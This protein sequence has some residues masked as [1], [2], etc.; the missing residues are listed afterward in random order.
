ME[1]VNTIHALDP[2]GTIDAL[3]SP[4]SERP[5]YRGRGRGFRGRGFRGRPRGTNS[6]RP[7]SDRDDTYRLQPEGDQVEGTSDQPR[8]SRGR[9]RGFRGRGRG[10]GFRGRGRGRGFRGR[11]RAFYAQTRS[12]QDVASQPRFIKVDDLEP[13]SRAVYLNLKVAKEPELVKHLVYSDGREVKEWSVLV[14]DETGVANLRVNSG[15]LASAM[16]PEV[17]LILRNGLIIMKDNKFMKLAANIWG[18][19]ELV[20]NP[21]SFEVNSTRNVSLTEYEQE[22]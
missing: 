16:K 14:G 21:H 9:G 2:T 19:I 18:K 3:V 22:S 15:D 11:G 20:S 10:R 1:R 7:Y 17:S 6:L 13:E 12:E 8:P 5:G 4:Q